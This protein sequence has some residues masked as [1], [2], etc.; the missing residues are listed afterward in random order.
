MLLLLQGACALAV[1]IGFRTR[2][3]SIGLFVLFLSQCQRNV[4]LCNTNDWVLVAFLFWGMFLPLGSAFS[5]DA[6]ASRRAQAERPAAPR[7]VD[8]IFGANSVA[9]SAQVVMMLCFAGL[10]KVLNGP[11]WRSGEALG[12]TLTLDL[13]VSDFGYWLG[14][15]LP[16]LVLRL[17]TYSALAAE[18]VAPWVLVLPVSARVRTLGIAFIALHMLGFAT[19]LHVWILPWF[20]IATLA[21]HLPSSL[22]E[23]LGGRMSSLRSALQRSRRHAPLAAFSS[24]LVAVALTHAFALN[25]FRLGARYAGPTW[26]DVPS[27]YLLAPQ[28]WQMFRDA[29]RSWRSSWVVVAGT[30]PARASPSLRLPDGGQLDFGPESSAA[31]IHGDVRWGTFWS[32]VDH[33]GNHHPEILERYLARECRA[34]Q[35]LIPLDTIGIVAV[36]RR[37]DGLLR[38]SKLTRRCDD[39]STNER[40]RA[41]LGE[42]AN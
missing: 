21:A 15:L 42:A 3:A 2:L 22:W 13:A 35:E 32:H 37:N 23:Q 38:E 16:P 7:V 26:L 8:L 28:G 29:D 27:G 10:Q 41:S 39:S 9:F 20:V 34:W 19:A 31:K 11:A 12:V 4:L 24:L 30:E 33:I 1:A 17:L 18:L 40:A 25:L 6:L 36:R 14:D 5:L